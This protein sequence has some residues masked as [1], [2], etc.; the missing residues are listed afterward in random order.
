MNLGDALR[1]GLRRELHL[2]AMFPWISRT[3]L[4][5]NPSNEPGQA[6]APLTYSRDTSTCRTVELEGHRPFRPRFRSI[7]VGEFTGATLGGAL[8][9]ARR[10]NRDRHLYIS[11]RTSSARP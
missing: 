8:T 7:V 11:S 10:I 4:E 9:F 5:R 1:A 3:C 2:G 6:P